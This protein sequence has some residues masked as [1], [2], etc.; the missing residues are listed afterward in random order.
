MVQEG[1]LRVDEA[2][3]W[4]SDSSIDI[5][6]RIEAVNDLL[7]SL[8][9][10]QLNDYQEFLSKLIPGVIQVLDEEQ[11]SFLS[12]SYEQVRKSRVRALIGLSA[13]RN[14]VRVF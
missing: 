1:S 10:L 7:E 12:L 2:I 13:T 5:K 14:C 6:S 8:D 3:L 9:A 4:L 11:P